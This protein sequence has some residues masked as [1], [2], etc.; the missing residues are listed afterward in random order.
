MNN[1]KS[2]TIMTCD[3]V[4]DH[5]IHE[6]FKAGFID[7][8]IR[9]EMSDEVFISRFFGPEGNQRELSHIAYEGDRPIAVLLGGIRE[10]GGMP[11]LRC[12]G[13]C[14]VPDHRGTGIAQELLTRHKRDAEANGCKQL[15]LEVIKGNDRAI[16][17]YKSQGYM[18]SRDLHYFN[19]EVEGNLALD[20]SKASGAIVTVPDIR[21]ITPDDF[22]KYHG[23]SDTYPNWQSDLPAIQLT[24]GMLY[25]GAYS[26]ERLIGALG[27]S[28]MGRIE[29]CHVEKPHRFKGIG[30]ALVHQAC[31]IL[32]PAEARAISAS[33]P[34]YSTFL[35]KCGFTSD[36]IA[37]HEMYL[38]L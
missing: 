28:P 10:F 22:C 14:V 16:R 20:M 15:F 27:M 33:L 2:I 37:Q 19:L 18:I 3:K 34:I 30:R 11:T 5:T 23:R 1:L 29:F 31:N 9:L 38:P 17:F 4:A 35:K 21:T 8:I 24:N 6:G 26:G 7:Y 13:L 25:L 36:P 12:G 32:S